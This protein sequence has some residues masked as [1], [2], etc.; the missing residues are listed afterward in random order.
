MATCTLDHADREA[1]L[2]E[3]QALRAEALISESHSAGGSV[4]VFDAR[5]DVRRRLDALIQAENGCCSFLRFAVAE[6]GERITVEVTSSP[7]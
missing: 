4:A 2:R 1:R 6:E 5:P 3:W 7:T